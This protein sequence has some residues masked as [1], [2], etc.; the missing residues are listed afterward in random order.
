MIA[1]NM[2]IRQTMFAK[3]LLNG[4]VFHR[5]LFRDKPQ[6]GDTEQDKVLK[7]SLLPLCPFPMLLM[8]FRI[9]KFSLYLNN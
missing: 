8:Y 3:I 9:E 4:L 5:T 1:L 7:K 6:T 2:L